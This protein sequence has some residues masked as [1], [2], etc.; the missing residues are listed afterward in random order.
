[1][2]GHWRAFCDIMRIAFAFA[3]ALSSLPGQHIQAADTPA[4][5]VISGDDG[6]ASAPPHTEVE[7]CGL[8]LSIICIGASSVQYTVRSYFLP[9]TSRLLNSSPPQ[10]CNA[11]GGY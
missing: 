2:S 1:M 7:R 5:P 9:S 11:I 3:R 6:S 10:C 4:V 8:W